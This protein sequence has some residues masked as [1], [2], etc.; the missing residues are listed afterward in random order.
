MRPSERGPTAY[1]AR[2]GRPTPVSPTTV[3]ADLYPL[4]EAIPARILIAQATWS[5]SRR[6]S[7]AAGESTFCILE[8]E[9]YESQL[10]ARASATRK[11]LHRARAVV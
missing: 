11:K 9:R 1:A 8:T 3:M 2:R 4:A 6:R 10:D 5:C 7:L